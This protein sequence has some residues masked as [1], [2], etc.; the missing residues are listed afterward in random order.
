MS[1]L[2]DIKLII[3]IRKNCRHPNQKTLLDFGMVI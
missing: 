2:Y 1:L 3:S